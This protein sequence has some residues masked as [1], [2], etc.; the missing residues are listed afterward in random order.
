VQS[1]GCYGL[2][3]ALTGGSDDET[4]SEKATNVAAGRKSKK[5]DYARD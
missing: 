1:D 2:T 4:D 5:P 3:L